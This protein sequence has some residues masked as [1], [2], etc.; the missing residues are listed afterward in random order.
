MRKV[1]VKLDFVRLPTPNL[2]AFAGNIAKRMDKSPFFPTP[3]VPL[4]DLSE[5]EK[6]LEEKYLSSRSGG[7]AEM[8]KMREAREALTNLLYKQVAY[9]ERM[10]NGVLSVIQNSGYNTTKQPIS[11]N[12]PEFSVAD[13]AMQGQVTVKHKAV[14]GAK[15]YLW[16]YVSDPMPKDESQWKL[17]GA[18]TK[19]KYLIKKLNS[20][21]WYWFRAIAIT[22]K[23]MLPHSEP[24]R[25][26]VS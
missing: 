10:A 1:K 4:K 16:Q 12:L 21:T 5:A 13:D 7:K 20:G 8:A 18:S 2:I 6:Y 9:V 24:I 11:K 15:A 22:S 3:D 26:L 14:Q 19:A 25:K 23:G 17:A